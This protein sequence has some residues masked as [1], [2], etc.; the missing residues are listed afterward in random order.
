MLNFRRISAD[1]K[2]LYESYAAFEA[3][4][5]CEYSFANIYMWG[6]QY[7]AETCGCAV[8][9]SRF[10]GSDSYHYPIG[11]GDKDAA[12]GEII[13]DAAGRGIPCRLS[14][15]TP[16]EARHLEELYPCRFEIKPTRDFYDYVYSTLDL[17]ELKGKRYH[18][19]MGHY[20]KFCEKHT[21]FVTELITEENVSLVREML[22]S[23][24]AEKE[25]S[26]AYFSFDTEKLALKRA[27]EARDKLGLTG[28]AIKHGGKVLAFAMAS[29]MSPDTFDIHF[30]KAVSTADG[31]YAAINREFAQYIKANHPDAVYLNREDDMGIEGLRRAKESYKPH[32]MVEKYT[33]VLREGGK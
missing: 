8:V 12:I 21:G 22:D 7:L 18:G 28:F 17:A 24:Y 32:H 3:E 19:K 13:A 14:G 2:A 10:G 5:G 23:W 27:F 9:F 4:R 33:G 6:E 20:R 26:D 1:D 30:E 16:E 31:A 11:R 25:V 15:M 29:R